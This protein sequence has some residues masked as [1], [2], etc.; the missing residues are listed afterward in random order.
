[1]LCR[2]GRTIGSFD[3][4]VN[5]RVDTVYTFSSIEKDEYGGLYEFLKSKRIVV[6]SVGKMDASKFEPVQI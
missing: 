5:I 2:S 1:M 3:I 6:K 4:K